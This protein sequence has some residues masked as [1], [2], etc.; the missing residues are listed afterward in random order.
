MG[1]G[2]EDE[3]D[4]KDAGERLMRGWVATAKLHRGR[5]NEGQKEAVK[6]LLSSTDRV[7]GVQGYAGTGKTT[8][9]GGSIPCG[10]RR[11]PGEGACAV[12]VGGANPWDGNRAYG[13]RPCNATSPAM[14]ES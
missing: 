4:G 13:A 10:K 2:R 3:R 7:V 12:R 1:D 14:R 9:M 5:L 11:L 8:M 6:L